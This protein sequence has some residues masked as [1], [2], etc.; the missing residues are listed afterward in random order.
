MKNRNLIAGILIV[1]LLTLLGAIVYASWQGIEQIQ[2]AGTRIEF[3]SM[4]TVSAEKTDESKLTV[5]GAVDLLLE[6]NYGDVSIEQ[7]NEDEVVIMAHMVAWNR[8]LESAQTD[9]EDLGYNVNQNGNKITVSFKHQNVHIGAGLGQS[10]SIDFTVYVP[11]ET[12]VTV[13]TGSGELVLRDINGDIDV[14]SGYGDIELENVEG[15]IKVCTNSGKIE[16]NSVKSSKEIELNS[17]YGSLNL[18]D[19]QAMN[20]LLSSGSGE[21]NVTK[22]SARERISLITGYGDVD[23][24]SGSAMTVNINSNSGDITLSGLKVSDSLQANSDYGTIDLEQ[25]AARVY[26]L[27]TNSGNVI[28][29][30]VSGYLKAISGYGDIEVS[31]ANK[32]TLDLNTNS[33]GIEF[34]GSLGK[35][36]HMVYSDYGEITMTIPADTALNFDF[37]TD[38][39]SVKSELEV[40]IT[41][42]MDKEHWIG[43]I[44]GGGEKIRVET[45]SGDIRIKIFEEQE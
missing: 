26:E 29:N 15:D 35:G 24:T 11:M 43:K 30:G 37:R 3:F 38:Y 45:N 6:T 40:T 34:S 32:V 23:F 12:S 42:E 17:N 13:D 8:N 14:N 41:G 25:V 1:T 9:L 19:A 33:G 36:P 7:G 27:D 31:H 44:N 21:I 4:D 20:I 16:A 10:D 22:T 5:D 2:T 28:V 18:N 39:G